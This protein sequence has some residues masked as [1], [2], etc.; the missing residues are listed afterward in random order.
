MYIILFVVVLCQVEPLGYLQIKR[1]VF[2]IITLV[3]CSRC[4]DFF[5]AYTILNV[6]H[7]IDVTD[8]KE[9]YNKNTN[10]AVNNC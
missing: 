1:I 3:C 7:Y 10:T 8:V 5:V 4:H 9:I 2:I 6:E